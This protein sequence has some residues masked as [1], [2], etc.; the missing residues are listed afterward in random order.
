MSD[1]PPPAGPQAAPAAP[2]RPAALRTR[3]QALLLDQGPRSLPDLAVALDTPEPE[4]DVAVRELLLAHEIFRAAMDAEGSLLV[5]APEWT[6]GLGP[7]RIPG[8]ITHVHRPLPDVLVIEFI[9]A[10]NPDDPHDERHSQS[11][12]GFLVQRAGVVHRPIFADLEKALVF[13][14][15]LPRLDEPEARWA[16][17]AVLRMIGHP[18]PTIQE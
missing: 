4:V 3:I 13:A 1:A 11:Q 9:S 14:I 12:I 10:P 15:C 7:V 18:Y 17:G 5:Y 16:A 2:P 8:D 6:T